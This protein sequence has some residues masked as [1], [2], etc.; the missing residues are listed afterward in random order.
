[1]IKYWKVDLNFQNRRVNQLS[2][3]N[4]SGHRERLFAFVGTLSPSS[5]TKRDVFCFE[6][7]PLIFTSFFDINYSFLRTI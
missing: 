7:K 2:K 4:H 3:D 1:M 5:G 6:M